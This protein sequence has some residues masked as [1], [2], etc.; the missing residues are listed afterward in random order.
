MKPNS[1]K[2][3]F[4]QPAKLEGFKLKSRVGN[5]QCAVHLRILSLSFKKGTT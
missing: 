2:N 5:P 4:E 3:K 1:G